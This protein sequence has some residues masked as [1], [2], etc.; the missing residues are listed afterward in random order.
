MLRIPLR[1][2]ALTLYTTGLILLHPALQTFNMKLIILTLTLIITAIS[3]LILTLGSHETFRILLILQSGI[4]L[5]S[6][7]ISL[8]AHYHF[9]IPQ[10]S[11]STAHP[12]DYH[13]ISL[14]K[15]AYARTLTLA[16]H[17]LL[18]LGVQSILLFL[19]ALAYASLLPSLP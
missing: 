12:Q 17:T 9:T 6:L 14:A 10:P 15:Y 2:L 16:P 5:L 11:M 3:L 8:A 19:I 1:S 13:P 4:L 18:E 7:I